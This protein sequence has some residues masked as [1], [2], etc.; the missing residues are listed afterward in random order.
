MSKYIVI[1]FSE[2]RTNTHFC[3]L[4]LYIMY[5]K[6]KFYYENISA[7][8]YVTWLAQAWFLIHLIDNMTLQRLL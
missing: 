4:S 6:L 5:L 1:L 3:P 8:G 7:Q 2:K